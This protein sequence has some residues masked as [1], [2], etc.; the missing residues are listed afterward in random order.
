VQEAL[1]ASAK[2]QGRKIALKRSWQPYLDGHVTMDA[3]IDAVAG[4]F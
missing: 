4:S 2:R 3:A 1:E